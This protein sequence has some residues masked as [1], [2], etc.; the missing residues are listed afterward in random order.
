MY[1][2]RFPA[3]RILTALVA[4]L[5]ATL[6]MSLSGVTDPAHASPRVTTTAAQSTTAATAASAASAP[7][8]GQKVTLAETSIDS[9]S[10]WTSDAGS[11][12]A[13]ITWT[14]TDPA[15]RLNLMSS[16]DG[17]AWGG[18]VTLAETSRFR[19]GLA[20]TGPNAS[21][22]AVVAWTGTD[23]NQSLNVLVGT[24]PSSA[25]KLTLRQDNSF[26][27]PSIVV[28]NGELYL[29]WAGT[30]AAHTLNVDRIS[31][32]A[33]SLS[34]QQK[35]ILWGWGGPAT[36]TIGFDPTGNRLVMS[37][38]DASQHVHFAYSTNGA[39][40]TQP[41]QSPLPESSGAGPTLFSALATSVSSSLSRYFLAWTGTDAAHSVNVKFTTSFPYWPRSYDKATLPEEAFGAPALGSVG[42]SATLLLAWTGTDAA[43]HLNVAKVA[44]PYAAACAPAAGV[45][46]T[47]PPT[48]SRGPTTAMDVSLTFDSDGGSAGNATAYL[49]I[50]KAHQIHAT[51]FLT[52]QFAQANP[53]IVQ[54][55][56]S[57]G[58]D[59]GNHTADHPDLANPARTDTYVCTE[60]T[61]ADSIISSSAGRS[62]RPY[63][64]PPYGSYNEQTQYLAAALGYRTI[65]WNIDPR[66]WDSNTTAQNIIDS[67]LNSPNLGPGA[68]ILMHVN[69]AHEAEALPSV[70]TGLQQR[71][72]TIVPLSQ[73]LR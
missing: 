1:P 32:G 29:A 42:V 57:D 43:H 38:I 66:D 69:S 2:R 17:A 22:R 23:A 34:V 73:L 4:L 68:I 67:V 58:H 46:P 63:F 12:R 27:A 50:L 71:G 62:T 37:W 30:D 13:L 47:I 35:T 24:P 18:K 45:Q 59:I 53:A 54:R 60:L 39:S 51:F 40:W 64:R 11:V 15:H 5:I 7:T 36:P 31:I 61:S 49:D 41:S 9:P 33:S 10:L 48:I 3:H 72:Y 44:A 19:A 25:I 52:G 28:Y 65:L 56:A 26:T 8:E 16:A 20:R 6:V 14:G 70:I 55:I 21:D